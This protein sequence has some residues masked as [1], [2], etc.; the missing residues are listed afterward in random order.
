MA[1]NVKQLLA[2]AQLMKF[3][4]SY[5]RA[6]IPAHPYLVL[7]Y[8]VSFSFSLSFGLL[9]SPIHT[10]TLYQSA[11]ENRNRVLCSSIRISNSSGGAAAKDPR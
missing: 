6:V 5:A 10:R 4:E 1:D 3:S 11:A 2:G 7:S 9:G 8:C